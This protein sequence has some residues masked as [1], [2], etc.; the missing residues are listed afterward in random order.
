MTN[1]LY[2]FELRIFDIFLRGWPK[3]PIFAS[4]ISFFQ[5]M[6]K[7]LSLCFLRFPLLL[8]LLIRLEMLTFYLAQN[9]PN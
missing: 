1:C 3:I 6:L 5:F 2:V 8:E 4:F 7:L 9:I